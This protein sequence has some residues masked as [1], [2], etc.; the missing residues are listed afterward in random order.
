MIGRWNVIDPLAEKS[1]RWS[2]YNYAINNPIRFIDPD[3]KAIENYWWGVSFTG[4]DAR[5]TLVGLQEQYRQTGSLKIH[6]VTE[7]RT[8]DIYR[9]TLNAFRK[10]KP[11]IL[12]YDSDRKRA[13]KRRREATGG[14]PSRFS[15][16]LVKDEY[17]YA[18]TFEGGIGAEV[19]Y[20]PRKQNEIQGYLELGPLYK[21]MKQ[22]EAYLVLPVPKDKE[23]DEER[24][25]ITVPFPLSAPRPI[26]SLRPLWNGIMRI[27]LPIFDP[28][29]LNDFDKYN[30][31]TNRN[32][33]EL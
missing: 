32:N 9:H 7:E 31:N 16:G 8:P 2:P 17:P 13:D 1:R 14:Y 29:L 23:P 15:E 21:T 20:V 26:P 25:P 18:S 10:G 27:L 6:Y 4:E 12:H 28:T 24:Q 3:G 19:A 22:G 30:P 11:N 33:R 5:Y